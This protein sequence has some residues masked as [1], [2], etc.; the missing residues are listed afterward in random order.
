[1]PKPFFSKMIKSEKKVMLTNEI[2]KK[3]KMRALCSK[4][5]KRQ[6]LGHS[7]WPFS[8]MDIFK[9]SKNDLPFSEWT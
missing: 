2:M 5:K 7:K 8:K 3:M 1:M 9:M 6:F 4:I